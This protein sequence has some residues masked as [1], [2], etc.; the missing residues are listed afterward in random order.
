MMCYKSYLASIFSMR[1]YEC[2]RLRLDWKC[3]CRLPLEYTMLRR[4]HGRGSF[5]GLTDKRKTQLL[6]NVLRQRWF[7]HRQ[8]CTRRTLL[9]RPDGRDAC[10]R[11]A[12][13]L[14]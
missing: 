3:M 7:P 2:K 11:T 14:Q 9:R 10:C 12:Q 5:C 8:I 1:I 13:E 6:L 4:G